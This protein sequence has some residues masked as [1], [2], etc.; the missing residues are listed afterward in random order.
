MTRWSFAPRRIFLA[1]LLVTLPSVLAA[2]LLWLGFSY[3]DGILEP[4]V[5]RTFH[6]RV[7]GVGFVALGTFIFLVGLFASNLLGARIVR[8][9]SRSLERI[10]VYSPVYRAV[11]DISQVFLGD[12]ASAFRRVV[13]IEWPRPGMWTVAFVMAENGGAAE[14]AVGRKLVT[15]FVPSTPNPTTGYVQLVERAHVYDVDMSVEQALKLMISG[16][17]TLGP[18]GESRP[19]TGA[20]ATPERPAAS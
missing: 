5:Q 18:G 17:A 12:K 6:R 9:V 10:P 11:R 20:G 4:L 8:A 19:R 7:P 14:V 3:F 13:M 2:Y 16:G 1:G 15:V